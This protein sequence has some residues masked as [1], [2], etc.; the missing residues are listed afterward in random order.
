M[1]KNKREPKQCLESKMMFTQTDAKNDFK[2]FCLFKRLDP[3]KL[4]KIESVCVKLYD[5]HY[6]KYKGV[7]FKE[8]LR[9]IEDVID[10]AT[11]ESDL[12]NSSEIFD[13]IPV[14]KSCSF[15]LNFFYWGLHRRKVV[16]G[17][18]IRDA[19]K[20]LKTRGLRFVP[21]TTSRITE[22]QLIDVVTF[23]LKEQL[24][25]MANIF[26]VNN[27]V[28]IEKTR[29]NLLSAQSKIHLL[30]QLKPKGKTVKIVKI[31]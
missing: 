21:S 31:L 18:Q 24:S 4:T 12:K 30:P 16:C 28:A 7:T 8:S 25:L 9:I 1:I 5:K 6:N 27:K 23:K 20:N 19:Y 3:L 10:T 15:C 14:E 2:N 13:V 11:K 29:E 17:K 22:L 26:Q